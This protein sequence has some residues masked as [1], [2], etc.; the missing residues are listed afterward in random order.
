MAE[1]RAF[2]ASLRASRAQGA[3]RA[4]AIEVITLGQILFDILLEGGAPGGMSDVTMAVNPTEARA[5]VDE[6]FT[7]LRLLL[8]LDEER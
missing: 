1:S 3:T 2:H 7:A 8:E 5:A 6:F 4:R